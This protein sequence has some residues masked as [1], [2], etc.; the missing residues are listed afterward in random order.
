MV[1]SGSQLKEGGKGIDIDHVYN[2]K[3]L[4]LFSYIGKFNPDGANKTKTSNEKYSRQSKNP[5][6]EGIKSAANDA[7]NSLPDPI[8]KSIDNFMAGRRLP[9]SDMANI[10]AKTE[11]SLYQRT[12]GTQQNTA[13]QNARLQESVRH[14]AALPTARCR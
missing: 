1:L 12:I 13:L 4:N 11:L 3:M 7:K 5:I 6:T 9:S 10:T 2:M 8:A 14:G